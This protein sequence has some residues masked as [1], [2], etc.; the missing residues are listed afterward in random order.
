ME[1]L[2]FEQTDFHVRDGRLLALRFRQ[3][4]LRD[5]RVGLSDGRGHVSF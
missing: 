5:E 4:F 2:L 1:W 3:K